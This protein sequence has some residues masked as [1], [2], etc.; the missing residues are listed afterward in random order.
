LFRFD[1]LSPAERF[2]RYAQEKKFYAT[3]PH[4]IDQAIEDYWE[5]VNEEKGN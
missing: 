3:L 5:Q 1:T 2:K 4:K